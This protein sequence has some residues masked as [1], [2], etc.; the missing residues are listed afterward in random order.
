MQKTILV[1]ACA[2]FSCSA[3][4]DVTLY[5]QIKSSISTGQVKIKGSAGTEK[6]AAATR[7]NDNASRI[8]FK[9]SEKL[10]DDLTAIWQLEQRAS[11]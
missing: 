3:Y 4:A 5:G 7:I 11:F 6:N 2:A 8:G 9:G 10:S 1:L